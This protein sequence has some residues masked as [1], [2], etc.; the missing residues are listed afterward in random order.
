MYPTFGQTQRFKPLRY[1]SFLG[2]PDPEEVREQAE[3]EA[4]QARIAA[5]NA[6]VVPPAPTFTEAELEAV[7]QRA[8]EDGR[9]QGKQEERAELNREAADR[10]MHTQRA[11]AA[12]RE[13]LL[14]LESE[15]THFILSQKTLLSQLALHVAQKVAGRALEENPLIEI[16]GMI[17]LALLQ[18][19][20]RQPL[21]VHVHPA[22]VRY[23]ESIYAEKAVLTPF[24]PQRLSF[25]ADATLAHPDDCR[26]EWT[27]GSM[28]RSQAE[29]WAQI[30]T[31][32]QAFDPLA[33]MPP[34]QHVHTEEMI[35]TEAEAPA[36][37]YP[38]DHTQE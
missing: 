36:P 19:G 2:E 6:A 37:E 35:Q 24:E 4:F 34:I 20:D 18:L 29:I 3:Y 26:V 31:V 27:N 5:E 17:G 30:Q 38:Q 8:F 25:H 33:A 22:I 11:L 16:E 21:K 14:T 23:M 13:Q 28:R 12:L 7:R 9:M 15:Q 1:K 32:L 10:E